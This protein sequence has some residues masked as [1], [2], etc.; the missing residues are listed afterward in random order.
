[1]ATDYAKDVL[2]LVREEGEVCRKGDD[3][4]HAIVEDAEDF[5][6]KTGRFIGMVL[7]LLASTMEIELS[8]N[9]LVTFRG[10]EYQ[11]R[12]LRKDGKGGYHF[13]LGHEVKR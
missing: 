10:A 8:K 12:R 2:F 11:V 5:D 1:M 3:E 9:D 7:Q 13:Q 4:F 6:P